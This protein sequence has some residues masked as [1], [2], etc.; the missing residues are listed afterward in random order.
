[1]VLVHPDGW[2][3]SQV[4][5]TRTAAEGPVPYLRL[6]RRGYGWIGDYRTQEQLVAA[7]QWWGLDLADFEAADRPK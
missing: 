1:V 4:T 6:A 7:L 3:I 2:V 5:L